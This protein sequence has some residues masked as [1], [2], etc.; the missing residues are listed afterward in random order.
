[1]PLSIRGSE[2]I[3]DDY[4]DGAISQLLEAQAEMSVPLYIVPQ[5]ITYGRRREKE[6]ENLVN[7]LFGQSDHTSA[8]QRIITFL[9][10]ANKAIVI[11][12]EA[13]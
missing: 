5:L 11:S 12:A 9:R 4:A 2:F 6:D 10:Y 1:V 7:I 8:L 13:L 3:E